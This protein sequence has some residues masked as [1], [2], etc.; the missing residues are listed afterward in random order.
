NLA[1]QAPRLALGAASSLFSLIFV[2]V[3]SFYLI[4]DTDQIGRNVRASAPAGYEVDVQRIIA[5]LNEIWSSFLRGQ[6]ILALIIG[7]VTTVALLILGVRSAL[8]LGLLAGVLEVVP[9]VGPIIAMIPAVLIA[10]FQGSMHWPIDNTVFALIV[11]GA[12]SLIQQLENHLIVPDVLGRSVNLLP[13]VI[14]FGALAGASLAGILGIFL[15]APVL[16]TAR[17]ALQFVLRK[18][19]EPLPRES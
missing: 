4:K 13:V 7:V 17:V 6:V 1:T 18:L 10:L 9:T 12:Y 19:L 15:A 5:D 14:L 16:A 3:M 8:L 2:L 11:V